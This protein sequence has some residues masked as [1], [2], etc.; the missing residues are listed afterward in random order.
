MISLEREIVSLN[1]IDLTPQNEPNLIQFGDVM[2]KYHE[3]PTESFSTM[4]M[5]MRTYTLVTKSHVIRA[6]FAGL[7]AALTWTQDKYGE[8]LDV[9][10]HNYVSNRVEIK[11]R[12]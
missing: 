7:N 2:L 1:D 6:T 9:H 4:P 10:V 11:D 3:T 5:I 12:K 8:V